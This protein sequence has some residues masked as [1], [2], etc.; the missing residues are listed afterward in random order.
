MNPNIQETD[1]LLHLCYNLPC[2]VHT[3]KLYPLP[4]PNGSAVVLLGHENGL[5]ILWRGGRPRKI[6]TKK[7]IWR[8]DGTL[9][10]DVA[11]DRDDESGSSTS[12][13]EGTDNEVHVEYYDTTTP[14]DSII[15]FVDLIF[16]VPVLH[17]AFPYLP[18]DAAQQHH[19]SYPTIISQKLVVA[20]VSSDSSVRLVTVPLKPPSASHERNAEA[21]GKLC[22]ADGRVD[23]YGEQIIE[24][25]N[26]NNHWGVPRCVALTFIPSSA[27]MEPDHE[28][29]EDYQQSARTVSRDRRRVKSQTRSRS[30]SSGV[31]DGWGVL[32]AS[33]SS[34]LS[35]L[36]LIY[37][38]PLAP[39][40]AGLDVRYHP[41]PVL[42][43]V[44]HL[45]SPAASIQFNPSLPYD[46]RNSTLLVAE[47]KGP[48]RLFDCLSTETSSQCSWLVSLFPG[49][50]SIT[51]PRGARNKL[52]DAQWVLGGKAILALFADGEWG[53]WDLENAGPKPQS[54]KQA[55]HV[56]ML[57]SFATFAITGSVHTGPNVYKAKNADR[58]I[59]D[60]GKA[61]KL[62]PNTPGT[63]RSRQ[64]DLFSGPVGQTEGPAH[65]GISVIPSRDT[66]ASD[67]A[68]LLWHNDSIIVISSLRTHWANKVKG[69]GNLFG[70]GAMGEARVISNVSLGGEGHSDV[71]HLPSNHQSSS[72]HSTTDVLVVGDSRFTIVAPPHSEQQ[73]DLRASH[74]PPSDQ[75]L[76]GNGSLDL[77]QMDRVLAN[78]NSRTQVSTS[79][80]NGGPSKRKVSFLGT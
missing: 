49:L 75:L 14:F 62:A 36:L 3:A 66:K 78:M 4:A 76:S 53:I 34:D 54:G 57:G 18:I 40:G 33:A 15:Q 42:W 37:R 22:V 23:S 2:R 59:K 38:V 67:E 11:V 79:Y 64:E 26:G 46:K 56:P 77:D 68:A 29:E 24:I 31:D 35:G 44:Q 39:H 63:R 65:G 28:M 80:V 43:T 48:V 6:Q 73:T 1:P 7:Q 9:E 60:G 8:N 19:S 10:P 5:R 47:A 58:M 12:D 55:P 61:A 71:C 41:Q 52:I 50:D 21:A 32:V 17:I 25:S 51:S 30:R 13:G 70:I 74:K 16:G 69:S 45:P 27:G 20:A 72:T